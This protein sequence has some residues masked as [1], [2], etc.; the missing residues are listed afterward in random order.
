[1][2]LGLDG[3]GGRALYFLVDSGADVSLVKSEKLLSTLEFEPRER[4]RIKSVKGSV[5]ATLGSV[6]AHILEGEL[7]APIK[8]QLVCK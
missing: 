5:V 8:L 2:V 3:S 6:E 4:V 1:M 7:S